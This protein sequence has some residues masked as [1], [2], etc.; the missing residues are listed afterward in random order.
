MLT[1]SNN[2]AELRLFVLVSSVDGNGIEEN[3]SKNCEEHEKHGA[4]EV[5]M[6]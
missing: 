1:D 5:S 4:E 3:E 6:W 2:G